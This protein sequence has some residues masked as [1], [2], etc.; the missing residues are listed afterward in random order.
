MECQERCPARGRGGISGDG[1]QPGETCKVCL[2]LDS[3][4][5]S[6]HLRDRAC[7]PR[8]ESS[9]ILTDEEG[10]RQRE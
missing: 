6:K 3:D 2:A 7:E 8:V 4:L 5:L 10:G 1:P 9:M